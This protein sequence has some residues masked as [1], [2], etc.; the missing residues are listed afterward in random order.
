MRN[1]QL[2][3][4]K[5]RQTV[6]KMDYDK[7]WIL[8]EDMIAPK[9]A[10]MKLLQ[11][12]APIVTGVYML[13]HGAPSSNIFLDLRNGVEPW[14]NICHRK[15]QVIKVQGG[16][17]GCLLLDRSVLEKCSFLLQDNCAPDTAFM[18]W[19]VK[20]GVQQMARLDVQCGHVRADGKVIYPDDEKGWRLE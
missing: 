12:D 1:V 15:N 3:Y 9:D 14:K 11:V 5:M 8:E 17:M 2:N 4:E 20:N 16:A 13:R 6:L 19:C 10:L 18:A 7:A